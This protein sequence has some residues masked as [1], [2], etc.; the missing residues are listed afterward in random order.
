V[1]LRVE[2]RWIDE[3]SGHAAAGSFGVVTVTDEGPGIPDEVRRSIFEPFFTTK[4]PGEGT[5]LG[6]SIAAD[7]VRDHGGWIAVD[8]LTDH[9]A[10]L[11]LH[12]PLQ[13]VRP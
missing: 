5:G 1:Q 9:G 10:R 7:I 12:V 13:A 2:S 3:P 4:D 8:N 6:L 11:S